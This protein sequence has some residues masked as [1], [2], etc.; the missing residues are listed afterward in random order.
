MKVLLIN[1]KQSVSLLT[2]SEA[3]DITG[4]P[5]YMPNL[6]LPTLAALSPGDVQVVQVDENIARVPHDQAWDLV[7]ITG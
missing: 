3:T 2:F 4:C 6:A 1:P 7:G 5:G